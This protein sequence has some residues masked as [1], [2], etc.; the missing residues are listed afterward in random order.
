MS[1]DKVVTALEREEKEPLQREQAH[2]HEHLVDC[3]RVRGDA[4][5]TLEAREGVYALLFPP[6][7]LVW[8][9]RLAA[10][11]LGVL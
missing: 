6:V 10:H 5:P 4:K 7:V 3:L 9:H 1:S 2:E 11:V 8:L